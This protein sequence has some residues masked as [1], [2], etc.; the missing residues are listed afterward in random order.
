MK[1]NPALAFGILATLAATFVW[2]EPGGAADRFAATAERTM[3]TTLDHYEMPGIAVRLQR[4]PLT[5]TLWFDG[6]ADDFQRGEILRIGREVPGVAAT[7]WAGQPAPRALPLLAEIMLM[8]LASFAAGAVLA[9][10]AA[11]RRRAREAI[12]A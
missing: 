3:R 11:L 8:A 5:R 10:I 2:H 6:R 4:G 7:A 12:Y 9:Y 1:R